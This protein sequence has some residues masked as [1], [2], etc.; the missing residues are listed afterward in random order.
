MENVVTSLKWTSNQKKKDWHLLVLWILAA[1]SLFILF[2]DACNDITQ[3]QGKWRLI[4]NL[5]HSPLRDSRSKFY[6]INEF[7]GMG[8]LPSRVLYRCNVEVQTLT[9][10]GKY[11]NWKCNHW[12]IFNQKETTPDS[13]FNHKRKKKKIRHSSSLKDVDSKTFSL[14]FSCFSYLP[15]IIVHCFSSH[16]LHNIILFI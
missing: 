11:N 15:L 13:I 6:Q 9:N 4:I 7:T 12:H 2:L 3:L 14:E 16:W 1:L 10:S 5:I 8:L